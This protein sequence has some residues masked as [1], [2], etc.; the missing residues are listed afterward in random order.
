MRTRE[1]I[2]THCEKLYKEQDATTR[3]FKL[4]MVEIELLLD[5]RDYLVTIVKDAQR[6][7]IEATGKLSPRDDIEIQVDSRA[8]L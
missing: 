1:Q 4:F 2:R 8:P 5:C 6:R 3:G 7:N